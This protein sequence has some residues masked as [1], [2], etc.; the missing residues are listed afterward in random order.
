LREG[1]EEDG[2]DAEGVDVVEAL[3]DAFEVAG[4]VGVGVAEGARVDL[5]EDGVLEPGLRGEAGA[6]P[7]GAGEGLGVESDG[8]RECGERDGESG[9]DGFRG[10]DGSRS[11]CAL[12]CWLPVA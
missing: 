11:W 7:A 6:D 2:V 1:G 12:V 10:S 9:E 5:V 4:A 3:G 8:A